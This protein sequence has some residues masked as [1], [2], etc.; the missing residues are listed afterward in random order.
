[1]SSTD[2]LSVLRARNRDL[3][4]QLEQLT[5][6]LRN[7]SRSRNATFSDEKFPE[8][9]RAPPETLTL[10]DGDRGTAR[11]ALTRATLSSEAENTYTGREDTRCAIP[12]PSGIQKE[13]ASNNQAVSS[14]LV[15]D[16]NGR[17]AAHIRPRDTRADPKS[18]LLNR[19]RKQE[20]ELFSDRHRLQPLLGYDWIAGILDTESSLIEHSEEFYNE[21]QV[22]RSL[23][24]DECVH[25]QQERISEESYSI[26]P[27]LMDKDCLETNVDT[28]Q[29]TFCYRINSR[30]FPVPL[31]SQECC[32][33]CKKPK[34]IHPHTTTEPA[35]IRVSIPRSTL[36]PAYKY[37]AH[38]RC[39]FDPSDSLGLPSH[40]LAGWLN[41]GQTTVSQKS[42]LDLRSNLHVK[43]STEL[44]S[45]EPQH[46]EQL[47]LSVPR[48]S[49]GQPSD[50]NLDV[51]R[52]PRY[53]FQ[54]LS[55][56][57]KPYNT[58]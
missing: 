57:S 46:K 40:C 30:L 37:K 55:P 27:L 7:L 51:S 17:P 31:D 5:E 13:R 8:E 42:N 47:D 12:T 54:H 19:D 45:P 38:R 14:Q 18:I 25:S 49:G 33:V 16:G 29:C 10:T 6:R 28:H 26:P 32:A 3:L 43:T 50:Q 56:K 41:T 4:M 2:P 15:E 21:L 24:K 36:L 52:L 11:A 22:F 1:M 39:S 48:V 34:S 58:A 9:D 23:N 35:L 53:R 20:D 44:P